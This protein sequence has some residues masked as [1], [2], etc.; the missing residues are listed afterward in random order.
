MKLD[1]RAMLAGECR[2]IPVDFSLSFSA[3]SKN[4]FSGMTDVR[5]PDPMTVLGT[6]T[7]TAGYM[8][9]KLTL[10]VRYVASC[11]RCLED[12]PGSFSLDVERTVVTP[13]LLE[14]ITE[15]RIDEFV[16]VEDG[17]LDIDE[18]LSEL[19]ELNLPYR[20]LCKEDCK[21]LCPRCG[22]NLNEG[23]CGCQTKETDP[24]W[25]PLR[26]ILEKMKAEESDAPIS[27]DK[28]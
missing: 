12:V 27:S 7:N 2:V 16:V 14:G 17:F 3:D 5:F 20:F 6:I 26:R 28:E 10:S 13:S 21:G 15:D 23:V 9:M 11:A 8:R 4:H 19:L 22:K 25:D 1:L 24:R 18:L